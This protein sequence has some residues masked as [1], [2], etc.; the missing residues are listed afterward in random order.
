MNY[1]MIGSRKISTRILIPH[2]STPL[3]PLLK[4]PKYYQYA[5]LIE[6]SW[7]TLSQTQ[8]YK[9]NNLQ[10]IM[11]ITGND[12]DYGGNFYY[13]FTLNKEQDTVTGS[14]L[15]NSVLHNSFEQTFFI[16][17]DYDKHKN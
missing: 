14:Y 2:L 1:P 10:N 17:Y 6:D 3:S 11:K 15:I 16:T 9:Y 5:D 13:R 4:T 12:S 7:D 8:A